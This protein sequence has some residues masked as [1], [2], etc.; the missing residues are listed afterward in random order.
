[1]TK[2]RV[3]IGCALG[4]LFGFAVGCGSSKTEKKK[5][6]A[7]EASA[8]AKPQTPESI[9]ATP[10]PSTAV[11]KRT[12]T[13][14]G[15]SDNGKAVAVSIEVVGEQLSGTFAVDGIEARVS[16]MLDGKTFRCWVDTE[17][18]A[19]TPWRGNFIATES[20]DGLTGTFILSDSAAASVLKG[21]LGA[22]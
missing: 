13:A 6:S 22:I 12:I 14:R 8:S 3:M 15:K 5:E 16:G 20:E 19:P 1:M 17:K 4:V 9:T 2:R 10:P 21:T 7:A 18:G 11:E